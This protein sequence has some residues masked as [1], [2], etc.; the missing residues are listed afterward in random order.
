MAA[1]GAP[2]S[3]VGTVL[4]PCCFVTAIATYKV[5]GWFASFLWPFLL[6]E[7]SL[8]G[9]GHWGLVGSLIAVFVTKTP[10]VYFVGY[11]VAAPHTLVSLTAGRYG[12]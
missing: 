2:A 12:A 9:N 7:R 1:G 11:K 4:A 8:G 10:P 5:L 3:L 6:R